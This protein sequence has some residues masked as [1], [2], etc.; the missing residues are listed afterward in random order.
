LAA[1][2]IEGAWI[3]VHEVF[4]AIVGLDVLI[5]VFWDQRHSV[6]NIWVGGP[7]VDIEV[8][9]SVSNSDTSDW[10]DSSLLSRYDLGVVSHSSSSQVR[11]VDSSVRLSSD[12]ERVVEVFREDL[13]P[14]EEGSKSIIGLSVVVLLGVL[15]IADGEAHT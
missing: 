4:L 6:D 9:G 14:G 3:S 13:V 5:Q 11:H 2:L 7:D 12:V 8:C 10:D 15:V 1:V